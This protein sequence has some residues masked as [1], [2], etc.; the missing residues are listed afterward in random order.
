MQLLQ[1]NLAQLKVWS[2]SCPDNFLA[3]RLM[4]EAEMAR[5][6]GDESAIELYDLA[7]DAA[8]KGRVR[9]G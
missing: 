8:R 9:A 2:E 4:V 1:T 5:I 3:K 6:T 7:V